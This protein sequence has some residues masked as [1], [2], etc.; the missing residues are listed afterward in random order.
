MFCMYLFNLCKHNLEPV[1]IEKTTTKLLKRVH[2]IFYYWCILDVQRNHWN[3]NIAVTFMFM[4]SVCKLLT[5]TVAHNC[6]CAL[7]EVGQA[8]FPAD[9]IWYVVTGLMTE[10]NIECFIAWCQS[11]AQQLQW[12]WGTL[13]LHNSRYIFLYVWVSWYGYI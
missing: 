1:S 13:T 4:M 7:S 11:G 9:G 2:Q 6:T 12:L 3:S 8:E 10:L 5:T